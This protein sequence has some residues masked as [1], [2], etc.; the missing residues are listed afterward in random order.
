MVVAYSDAGLI[1]IEAVPIVGKLSFYVDN[2][3]SR[4]FVKILPPRFHQKAIHYPLGIVTRIDNGVLLSYKIISYDGKQNYN[5]CKILRLMIYSSET[6]LWNDET[7]HLPFS[8]ELINKC[9]CSISLNGNLYLLA[10]KDD[11]KEF[12]LS[13][14]YNATCR[15][16]PFPDLDKRRKFERFFTTSQGNLM[17]MNIFF[18]DG[19][20]DHKLFFHD[21]SLDHKLCVWTLKSWEWQLVSEIS[22]DF[23]KTFQ[24]AI[25]LF[26]ATTAYFRCMKRHCLLSINLDNGEFVRY[27][28]DNIFE[29]Y[30][31]SFV[32]P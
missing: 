7:V 4:E 3:V 6:G 2:P 19:S 21:G 17:Y 23:T 26:D 14:D 29:C 5:Y 27:L 22:A 30:Y 25:N 16:T 28:K 9:R 32:L 24:L 1:L 15:V 8:F 20:L 13:I 10:C 11:L 31:S 18:H 12:V